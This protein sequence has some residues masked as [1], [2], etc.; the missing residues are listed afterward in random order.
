MRK[1]ITFFS[2]AIAIL[3]AFGEGSAFSPT[4]T[5]RVARKLIYR[6]MRLSGGKRQS[7]MSGAAWGHG[8]LRL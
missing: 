4:E 3:V 1:I 7:G 2:V 8:S 5:N 6:A